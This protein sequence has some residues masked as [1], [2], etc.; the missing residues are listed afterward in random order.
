MSNTHVTVA[1]NVLVPI[2]LT[3]ITKRRTRPTKSTAVFWHGCPRCY[4]RDTVN[5]VNGKTMQ[6]LH[7]STV[8]KIEH[9]RRQ[10]YN[11]VEIWECDVNRELNN[12]EDMKYYFD[13]YH[14]ADPLEPRDALYGGRAN[15]AKLYNRCQGDEQIK[16]VDFAS[17]YPHV[18][19]SKAVP[20]GHP[21]IITENLTRTFPTISSCSNARYYHLAVYSIP[22]FRVMLKTS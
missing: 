10:G 6:E 7:C 16:Y 13:H 9:L 17:L 11:V 2:C 20:A 22:F 5:P 8:E 15:A 12:D 14:I 18:N 3:V 21:E 19:R 4:A 1:R